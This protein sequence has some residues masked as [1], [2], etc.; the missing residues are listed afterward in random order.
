[1]SDYVQIVS[2]VLN[3]FKITEKDLKS[4]SKMR[5]ITLAKRVVVSLLHHNCNTKRKEISK[6]ADMPY[7]MVT[8]YLRTHLDCIEK[9]T[10]YAERFHLCRKDYV[11]SQESMYKEQLEELKKEYNLVKSRLKSIL[12]NTTKN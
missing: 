8:H 2:I 5:N 10:Y 6:E 3:R 12:S 4:K 1:M 7:D 9:D 11:N